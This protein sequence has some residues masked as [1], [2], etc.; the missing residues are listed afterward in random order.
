MISLC[1]FARLSL[2]PKL[3]LGNQGEWMLREPSWMKRS[4][5]S[6]ACYYFA[7]S[8]ANTL[9]GSAGSALMR[10]PQALL[11]ALMIEA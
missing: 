10:T 8:P 1:A 6:K 11:M 4:F 9:S 7:W 2:V 3:E 5:S